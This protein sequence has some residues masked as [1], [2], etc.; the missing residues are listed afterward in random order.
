MRENYQLKNVKSTFET[1]D[2]P[3]SNVSKP[4]AITKNQ[5]LDLQN[6]RINRPT[7]NRK[8]DSR[9]VSTSC[10]RLNSEDKTNKS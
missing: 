7:T 10:E 4:L 2:S 5:N 3:N 9:T 8:N 1:L 6:G